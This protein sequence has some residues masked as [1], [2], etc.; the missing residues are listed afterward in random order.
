M[1]RAPV[2]CRRD[3]FL[4]AVLQAGHPAAP[5][6]LTAT[7]RGAYCRCKGVYCSHG[8][9]CLVVAPLTG[10]IDTLRKR[11][12][13]ALRVPSEAS[14]RGRRARVHTFSKRRCRC[15]V[16]SDAGCEA[17]D[18]RASK[19]RG[20]QC[21]S[22]AADAQRPAGAAVQSFLH[23]DLKGKIGPAER[24]RGAGAGGARGA[25]YFFHTHGRK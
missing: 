17:A 19:S 7:I 11:R 5:T 13:S 16:N 9:E 20:R 24:G 22:I 23:F 8:E 15:A 21:A 6:E 10:K 1:H 25:V 4:R 2:P 12:S 18:P 3:A 14:R